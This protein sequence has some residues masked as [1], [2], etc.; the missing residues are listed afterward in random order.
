MREGLSKWGTGECA[1][2]KAHKKAAVPRMTSYYTWKRFKAKKIKVFVQ[3]TAIR[4]KKREIS[5]VG[6]YWILLL[7]DSLKL[8]GE[9]GSKKWRIS[10]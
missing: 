7:Y 9:E 10:I 6:K 5:V 4:N 3:E 8:P 1:E 2:Q